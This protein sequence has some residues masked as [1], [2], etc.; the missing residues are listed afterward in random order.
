MLEPWIADPLR[1]G[2]VNELSRLLGRSRSTVYWWL[3]TGELGTCGIIS[4]RDSHGRWW[5][6]IPDKLREDSKVTV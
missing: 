3:Y 5:L 6:R 2:T 4:H 1:W